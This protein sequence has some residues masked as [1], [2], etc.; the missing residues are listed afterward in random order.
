M[1]RRVGDDGVA[2]PSARCTRPSSSARRCTCTAARQG[3]PWRDFGGGRR[4]ADGGAGRGGRRA[5]PGGATPSPPRPGGDGFY[6]PATARAAGAPRLRRPVAPVNANGWTKVRPRAAASCARRSPGRAATTRCSPSARKLLLYGGA[7]CTPGCVLGAWAFDADR[8]AWSRLNA[9][10]APIHRQSLRARRRDGRRL[11]LRR[12]VVANRTCTTTP[13]TPSA[14]PPPSPPPPWPRR[15]PSLAAAGRH[16]R[17]AARRELLR[18]RGGG[19]GGGGGVS[20][21]GA[22]ETGTGLRK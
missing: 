2:P 14:S 18:A 11:P 12:R 6:V 7:L 16:R 22:T 5:H 10:N 4:P 15:A 17:D 20:R 1:R 8:A 21:D 19:G 9:T 3:R 13:S